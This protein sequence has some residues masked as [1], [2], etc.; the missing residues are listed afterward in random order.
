[1]N[2]LAVTSH[3]VYG[4]V[5][6]QAAVPLLQ[7]M[8][9]EAWH[10]PTVLFS[11]HPGHGGF[12]GRVLEPALVADLVAGLD[13]RGFL[14]RCDAVLGGYLGDPGTV[15]VL[16]GAIHRARAHRPGLPV[17]VDPVL[18]DA[19]RILEGVRDVLLPLADIV[20]PNRHELG[21]LAGLPVGDDAAV[22]AAAHALREQGPGI[23]VVTSAAETDTA[24]A[25][26]LVTADGA[27][28]VETPRLP[29]APHG[30]GD[31]FAALFLGHWL[32]DRDATA[33]LRFA[34][35]RLA[36]ILDRGADAGELP[37]VAALRAATD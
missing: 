36:G 29:R 10:V 16:A 24:I 28:R 9:H 21:W 31:A 30:T 14:A 19:G 27:T 3:V 17:L 18:G 34:V 1:M 2:V 23:V 33:A 8:G 37:L 4:H 15:A 11:N 26:L 22:L 13:E 20:T 32:A 5:G 35:S 12:R 25:T 7:A 6:G